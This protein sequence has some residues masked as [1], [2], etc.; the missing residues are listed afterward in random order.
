VPNNGVETEQVEQ[1]V[2]NAMERV[3]EKDDTEALLIR[4]ERSEQKKVG[5]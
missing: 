2:A 4:C 5:D 1:L 3:K